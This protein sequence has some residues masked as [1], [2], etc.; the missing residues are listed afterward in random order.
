MMTGFSTLPLK[1][2]TIVGFAFTLFGGGVLV[3][4]VGRYLVEGGAVPGSPFSPRSSRSFPARSCSRSGFSVSTWR[5]C[6]TGAPA[7]PSY[8]VRERTT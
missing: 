5:A 6:S 8:T 7:S 3:Y 2:A 1:L 4:V